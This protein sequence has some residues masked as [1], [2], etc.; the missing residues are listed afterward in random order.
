MFYEWNIEKSIENIKKHKISFEQA[1]ITLEDPFRLIVYDDAHSQIED[2]Y[3]VIGNAEMRVLLVI[4]AW[5]DEDTIRIISAR[6]ANRKE[7]EA[8]NENCSLFF[9]KRT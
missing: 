9:G 8:Y 4:I 1:V 7:M 5:T 3:I 6:R 2:R